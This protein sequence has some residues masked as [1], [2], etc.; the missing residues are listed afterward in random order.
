MRNSKIPTK[1]KQVARSKNK[2]IKVNALIKEA[3][4]FTDTENEESMTHKKP[5]TQAACMPI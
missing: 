5:M 3:K 4:D 2:G 1:A